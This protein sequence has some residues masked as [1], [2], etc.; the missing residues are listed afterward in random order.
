MV[1]SRG[2]Q[3]AP[4]P[5]TRIRKEH[6]YQELGLEPLNDRFRFPKYFNKYIKSRYTLN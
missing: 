4:L 6:L 5:R 1:D 2:M 3:G